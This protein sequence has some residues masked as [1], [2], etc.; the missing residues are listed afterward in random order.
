M[1]FGIQEIKSKIDQN[2]SR[3]INVLD[4]LLAVLGMLSLVSLI[5]GVGFYHNEYWT[6]LLWNTVHTIIVIF[7]LIEISKLLISRRKLKYLKRRWVEFLIIG[8]LAY[9]TL[10][11]SGFGYIANIIF[12]HISIQKLTILYLAIIEISIL[13]AVVTK[14]LR[15][16]HLLSKLDLHPGAIM[17]ISFAFVILCGALLLMMPR[18]TTVGNSLSFIDAL[19]TS[20]SAVCVTGLIVVDTASAFTDLGKFIIFFLI[21]IGGL[22]IMTLTTFFATILA[23]GM[24]F[25]VSILMR[26]LLSEDSLIEVRSLLF[27]ITA[28]TISIELIGAVFLYTSLGGCFYNFDIALFSNS[29]FH[30]VSAFCNAGFSIYTNGLGDLRFI[31]NYMFISVIMFLVVTGGLSFAVMSNIMQKFNFRLGKIKRKLNL[32]SKIV[33]ISTLILIVL[34]TFLIMLFSENT[35]LGKMGFWDNL[36]HSLFLS[37]TART[38]GFN[39]LP[40]DGIG[41]PVMFVVMMLMWIGA[42]PGSTGGGVKNSTIVLA[43]LGLINMVT[44]K[45]RIELFKREIENDSVQKALLVIF[46]SI[47]VLGISCIVLI[48]IERS[49]DPLNLIFE[50]VSAIS[51]VGLTRGVTSLLSNPGK[52]LIVVLMFIGRI[53]VLT[54]FMSFYIP[55]RLPSYNLPRVNIPVG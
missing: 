6:E 7:I 32:I 21:Q 44:G 31:N 54:F 39:T 34:G 33:I 37:I 40:I 5:F 38:A 52:I 23:G 10:F 9:N 46:S 28:F 22:G 43:F 49:I 11:P 27:K 35:E 19:F 41:I 8:F 51:T 17:S 25:K 18:A 48:F 15:Y 1:S 4:I 24:S 30:S 16:N 55:K 26:D 45:G 29:L 53:G 14:A 13:T 47:F 2:R 3:Y 12:P 42:S 20:T 50:C 36:F